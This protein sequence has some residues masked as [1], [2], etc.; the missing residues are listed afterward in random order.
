MATAQE[1]INDAA[2]IAG[3]LAEGQ[4]IGASMNSIILRALNNM[5]QSWEYLALPELDF[6]DTVRVP[7]ADMGAIVLNLVNEIAMIYRVPPRADVL[8]MAQSA[9]NDMMIRY[10][11]NRELKIPVEL[12]IYSAGNILTDE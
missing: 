11:N 4:T 8:S 2:T 3:V 6:A 9:L 10:A 7:S 1:I 12:Q 5:L